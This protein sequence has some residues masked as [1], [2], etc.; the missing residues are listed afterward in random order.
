[1]RKQKPSRLFDGIQNATVLY[2]AVTGIVYATLLT[3]QNLGLLVPWVNDV[4][5]RIMPIV[6]V[7]DWLYQPARTKLKVKHIWLLLI[8]PIVFLFYSLIR[9]PIVG[10][11]PYPFLNPRK[12]GGYLGVAAYCVGI[13]VLFIV[14]SRLLLYSGTKLKRHVT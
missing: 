6:I 9:G 13:L 11:Y 12:A 2:M 5:H 3:G 7:A 10:W 8:F 14:L 4:Y 1:M